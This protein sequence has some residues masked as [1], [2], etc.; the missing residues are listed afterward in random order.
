MI[1][2][3]QPAIV[4]TGYY[5]AHAIWGHAPDLQDIGR[6]GETYVGTFVAVSNLQDSCTTQDVRYTNVELV[7]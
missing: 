6:M 2:S 7:V 1:G 4:S 3:W 5:R